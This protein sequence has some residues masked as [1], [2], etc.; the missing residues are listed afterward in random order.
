MDLRGFAAGKYSIL[1]DTPLQSER[2]TVLQV[3]LHLRLLRRGLDVRDRGRVQLGGQVRRDQR[4]LP[5][6]QAQEGRPGVRRRNEGKES[7]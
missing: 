7:P 5:Q 6:C 2:R 3:G 4:I 1:N